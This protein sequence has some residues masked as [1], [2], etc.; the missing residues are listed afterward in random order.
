MYILLGLDNLIDWEK[1][2]KMVKE[3]GEFIRHEEIV[4]TITVGTQEEVDQIINN[5]NSKPLNKWIERHKKSHMEANL[6]I[7]GQSKTTIV[8]ML[9]MIIIYFK[10]NLQVRGEW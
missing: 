2:E 5:L 3:R 1:Y 7:E 10:Y 6:R 8:D 9:F 4:K